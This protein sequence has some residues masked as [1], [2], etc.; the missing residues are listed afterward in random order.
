MNAFL[1]LLFYG[2]SSINY[3]DCNMSP[4]YPY[5]VQM[6][7]VFETEPI[8]G[9][10]TTMCFL[11]NGTF[12]ILSSGCKS[13]AT[14]CNHNKG[15][16][17]IVYDTL[18]LNTFHQDRID[19]YFMED[20][21]ISHDSIGLS[22]YST[23]THLPNKGFAFIDDNAEFISPNDEGYIILPCAKKE[24]LEM[25]LKA[26]LI[27]ILDSIGEFGLE[28]GKRYRYYY[29]D[30]YKTILHNEKFIILDSTIKECGFGTVYYL[31]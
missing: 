15:K 21:D 20:G 13:L 24:R 6:G 19:D 25:L 26:D 23:N 3:M 9:C 16:W 8:Q 28:C 7:L 12:S 31:Q 5:C 22:V 10:K 2:F 14:S 17:S 30:C 1:L 29:K 4:L 18:T 27:F 11:P